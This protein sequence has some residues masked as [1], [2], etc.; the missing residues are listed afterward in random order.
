MNKSSDTYSS[1][2]LDSKLD[3]NRNV[4]LDTLNEEEIQIAQ[5]RIQES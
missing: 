2:D 3:Q 5:Q 4:K 1:A